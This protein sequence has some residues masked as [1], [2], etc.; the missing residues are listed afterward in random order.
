MVAGLRAP[1]IQIDHT[2]MQ[3]HVLFLQASGGGEDSQPRRAQLT[4]GTGTQWTASTTGVPLQ[5]TYLDTCPKGLA[6]AAERGALQGRYDGMGRCPFLEALDFLGV[7]AVVSGQLWSVHPIR[8]QCQ[9][10]IP[11]TLKVW[12]QQGHPRPKEIT[13]ERFNHPKTERIEGAG[14][15]VGPTEH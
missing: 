2:K 1:G 11:E 5:A 4:M 6:Q 14:P 8:F 10:Q 3:P 13:G 9:T 7:R 15:P 12:A